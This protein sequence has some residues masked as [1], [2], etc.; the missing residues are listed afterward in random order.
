MLGN[1]R[2]FEARD[3][4]PQIREV[5]R[6]QW[7]GRSEGQPDTMQGQR[8]ARPNSRQAFD[9]RAAIREIVLAM[10][11]EPRRLRRRGQH[12]Q[13]VLSPKP[14]AGR[15][16]HRAANRGFR[17]LAADGLLPLWMHA[18]RRVGR[19]SVGATWPSNF[20]RSAARRYPWAA[21]STP[22]RRHPSWIDPRRHAPDRRSR[23][24][25]TW[26]C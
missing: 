19:R 14:D 12:V 15:Y 6:I 7:V 18:T 10:S 23:S 1:Q 25:R 26:Q 5:L 13:M 9:V 20:R 17:K 21:K 8:I 24:C 4:A 11:L 22:Y 16:R 3:G 2:R